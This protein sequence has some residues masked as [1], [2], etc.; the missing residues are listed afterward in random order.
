M[1]GTD[2]GPMMR[3]LASAIA[4]AEGEG[5]SVPVPE[6][7]GQNLSQALDGRY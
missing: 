5:N 2:F 1:F 4:R 6:S 3:A 7:E